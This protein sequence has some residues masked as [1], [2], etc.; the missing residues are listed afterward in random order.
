MI[1][2]PKTVLAGLKLNV[3]WAVV[4]SSKVAVMMM[5]LGLD[6]AAAPPSTLFRNVPRKTAVGLIV[7]AGS[8]EIT[9]GVVAG[10]LGATAK[11]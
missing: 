9:A 11:L 8:A 4:W 6:S 10:E 5:V 7:C 1:A 3:V 2:K